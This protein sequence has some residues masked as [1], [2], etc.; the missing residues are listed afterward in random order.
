M[1]N[2][3]KRSHI[4]ALKVPCPLMP[5][6]FVLDGNSDQLLSDSANF[7]LIN[8]TG[9]CSRSSKVSFF[10]NWNSLDH[11]TTHNCET[12][13][14]FLGGGANVFL[15]QCFDPPPSRL[16]D[17]TPSKALPLWVWGT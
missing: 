7:Y 14:V 3:C 2:E 1:A 17:R 15:S 11:V 16:F 9:F 10:A 6:T 12:V 4:C 5:M 13:E 8:L